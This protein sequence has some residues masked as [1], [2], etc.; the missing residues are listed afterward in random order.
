LFRFDSEKYVEMVTFR[1]KI[2][3]RISFLLFCVFT[4][5]C[6][7]KVAVPPTP[8]PPPATAAAPAAS[9]L[10]AYAGTFK[11]DANDYVEKISVVMKDGVLA[12]AADTG[13]TAPLKASGKADVFTANVQGYDAEISFSRTAG[14]VTN[15]RISVGGGAVVLTG[16]KQ[17]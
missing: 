10:D 12:L 15:I 8:P 9:G 16:T 3:L 17:N 4:L 7:K 14:A 11:L 2:M 5:A 6:T 13:D 1:K